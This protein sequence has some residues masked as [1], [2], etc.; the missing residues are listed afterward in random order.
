MPILYLGVNTRDMHARVSEATDGLNAVGKAADRARASADDLGAA[1]SGAT[2]KVLALVG[3]YKALDGVKKFVWRGIKFNST[4]ESSQI[5]MASIITSMVQLEDAQGK[6]LQG[7]QKYAAAQGIAADMMKEIQRLGLE[8]TATTQELVEGVQSVMGSAVQAGMALKDIPRFA[9]AGAQAMQTLGIPLE[10]MRTELDALLTGRVNGVQDILAPKLFP[11]IP[12]DKLGEYLRGL[13]QSGTLIDELHKR[14]EP[15]RIAGQDVAQTWKGLMSNLAEALD[16][17]SAEAGKGLSESLKASVRELQNLILTTENGAPRISDDF[18]NIAETISKIESRMGEALLGAVQSLADLTRQANSALSGIDLDSGLDV[19]TQ[20]IKDV[21]IA[22]GAMRLARAAATAAQESGFAADMKAHGVMQALMNRVLDYD[23]ALRKKIQT[24]QQAA[25]TTLNAAQADV[26]RLE[27]QKLLLL[28]QERHADAL[29]ARLIGTRNEERAEQALAAVRSR[30]AAVDNQLAAAEAKVATASA[31]VAKATRAATLAQTAWTGLRV[32]LRGVL[33]MF[34]GPLGVAFTAGAAILGHLMTRQSE[35]EKAAELHSRALS[36]LEGTLRGAIDESG[37]LTRE[38]TNLERAQLKLTRTTLERSYEAQFKAVGE[39]VEE[40]VGMFE[41]SAGRLAFDVD[42]ESLEDD[43]AAIHSFKRELQD[44]WSGFRSGDM[45]AEDFQRKMSELGAAVNESGLEIDGF[46]A[47][48]DEFINSQ[49]ASVTTLADTAR[50]I[51]K[52]GKALDQAKITARESAAANRELEETR[53]ALAKF[54][55]KEITSIAEAIA[56]GEKRLAQTKVMQTAAETNARVNDQAALS[57][58]ELAEAMAMAEV[59][60]ASARAALLDNA[61]AANK[62][63]ADAQ[64]HLEQVHKLRQ[65]FQEGFPQLYAS[66]DEKGAKSALRDASAIASARDQIRAFRREIEEMT[67]NSSKSLTTLEDKFKAIDTAARKAGMSAADI[68]ALKQQYQEAFQTRTL[69]DFDRELLKLSGDTEALRQLEVTATLAE[70]QKMFEGLGMTAG[71]VAAQ[72]ERL[73]AALAQ[74]DAKRGEEERKKNLELTANFYKELGDLSG[75]YGASIE[76][77]NRL[78]DEQAAA[79]V[80]AGIPLGD[81]AERVRLIKL[82]LSQDPF[83]GFVRGAMKF[84][85]EYGDMAKQVES[86]TM[87]MGQTIGDSLAD[88]FMKGEISASEFFNSLVGMA[89][90]AASNMF[91]S[92]I[93]SGIGGML[94]G[95]LSGFSKSALNLTSYIPGFGGGGAA[96]RGGVLSGGNLSDYSGTVVSR[97]TL[98]SY[99]SDAHGFR[100]LDRFASGAGLMGE[101]G[102]EA[103]M[104]LR[105]MPGGEL[106]VRMDMRA[107][108]DLWEQHQQRAQTEYNAFVSDYMRSLAE[109]RRA[110]GNTA[111]GATPN[112]SINVINQTDG[113]VEAQGQARSDGNGGFTLDIL[114]T[115]V[116]QGLVQRAKAGRSGLMQY[117]EQAYGLSRAGMLARGRR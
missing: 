81:V 110:A 23:D 55:T 36:N 25:A 68:A 50:Q 45:S 62:M 44:I 96:A 102:P 76:Y 107:Y 71:G 114:L 58:L 75:N 88:A 33:T 5:G 70:W 59:A 63:I 90:K 89:A 3:A 27:R 113:Q 103:I 41:S 9:V 8:T 99:A 65:Q 72:M 13:K 47:F 42:T 78:I 16:V 57:Y 19:L 104:P 29:K 95:G 18:R 67:G 101:A 31:A 73:K 6:T 49:Q 86:F 32:A 2:K 108:E 100:P 28:A 66:Q 24:E 38:L 77:Q 83:D 48:F 79:W 85:A 87:Q 60:G 4:L 39:Q 74:Q 98:F 112:I 92:Q 64:Q 14:F 109:E 69:Q 1:I 17:V 91:I 94:G 93:F 54:Q 20:G 12:L 52:I 21:A 30:L 116:E 51:G 115:Q 43:I 105:R 10:Q 34:G 35:A 15:F 26:T 37:K 84:G 106:G 22:Y 11:E 56:W 7:A 46:S 53:K 117:Q 111:A 40:L 97:P 61:E 80:N 82:E